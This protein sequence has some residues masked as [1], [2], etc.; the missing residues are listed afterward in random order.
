MLDEKILDKWLSYIDPHNRNDEE[1]NEYKQFL[2]SNDFKKHYIAT[3]SDGVFV[4][5]PAKNY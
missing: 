3:Y 4:K 1:Y 5:Y 2:K